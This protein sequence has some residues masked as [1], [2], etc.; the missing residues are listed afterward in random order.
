MGTNR[1]RKDPVD[2]KYKKLMNNTMLFAISNFSSKLLS[3]VLQPYITFAMG[4]VEEVGIT[5]L[6]QNIGSLLIPLVSMGV[7]FAIIRFGL[8]KQNSKSQVF[9]N[10]LVTILLGFGLMLAFYPLLRLIPLFNTYALLLYV[11]VLVSCLRTLCTQF[12]RSRQ[13]NR[14]VALDGV[15]CS[16]TNLG[17]MLLFLSGLHLGAE[18]YVLALICSD[19]LSALFVFVIAGLRRYLR[20]ASFNLPLWK[21]MMGYALPMVPAQISF[22]II[23]ASDLFFV[24]VMCNGYEGQAGEYWTGLLG[25]GYFLP[26]ILTVLG[27]I[28]YEAWQLSAVTEEQGRER[29]FSRVFSLYQ[30][31]LFCCCAGIVLL[32]RPLM[33]LFKANFYEAWQFVPLLTI[34]TLFNCLNQFLNSIYMV[35]KRSTLSLYT[36]MAGAVANCALNWLFI[37]RMGPNGV[38]LASFL[39][40]L[41][42]FLLRAVNTRGLLRIDFAPVKLV[43]NG[44]MVMAEVGL[45]LFQ[46]PHW[47]I[48]C[49][50]L[51]VGVC[52]FN[53]QGVLGMLRQLLGRRGRRA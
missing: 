12:V 5:K 52:A 53:F 4:E 10:G 39:S 8:E 32:C 26:T 22:W 2:G 11:H 33:F 23:N 44:I 25:V 20:F 41:L 48:W 1:E 49:S 21:K 47:A 6:V 18:G 34:A 3:I 17:F 50:L 35:E 37:P 16:A 15:L 28:F 29:F 24:K 30:S 42:V 38:T 43:F 31:L 46:A 19:A 40:Y 13:I 7:S 45:M 9:T 36:M 51:T 14:L 27:T